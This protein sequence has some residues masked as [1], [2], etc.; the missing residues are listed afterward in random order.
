MFQFIN[1]ISEFQRNCFKCFT[2][3]HFGDVRFAKHVSAKKFA[4]IVQFVDDSLPNH[5]LP[6]FLTFLYYQQIN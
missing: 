3:S 5:D 1:K 2:V 6:T 4:K